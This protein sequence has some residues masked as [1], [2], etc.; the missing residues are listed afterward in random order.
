MIPV[1]RILDYAVDI[2]KA[3]PRPLVAKEICT[4]LAPQGHQHRANDINPNALESK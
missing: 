2:L 3:S 1:P 4:E